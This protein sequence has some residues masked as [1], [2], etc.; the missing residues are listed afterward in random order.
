ML[1]PLFIYFSLLFFWPFQCL[2]LV[3]SVAMFVFSGAETGNTDFGPME[4]ADGYSRVR[5]TFFILLY[6][7]FFGI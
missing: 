6:N 1:Q 7:L 3:A 4:P 5:E 2:L